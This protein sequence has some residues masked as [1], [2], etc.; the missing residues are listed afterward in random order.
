MIVR[1]ESAL[2]WMIALLWFVGTI[3]LD[4]PNPADFS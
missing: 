1:L 3:V 4:G 2:A